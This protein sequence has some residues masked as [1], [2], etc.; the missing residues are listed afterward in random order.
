MLEAQI[1]AKWF[2]AWA[3]AD[4]DDEGSLT[5]LKL[6]K[7]LYYAQGHHLAL[8]G[9]PLF[10]DEI[11]AWKHGPVVPSVYRAY[12]TGRAEQLHLRDDDPFEFSDVDGETTGLLIDIW[13]RYGSLAA[14]R[15]RE[16]THSEPPWNDAYEPDTAEIVISVKALERFFKSLYSDAR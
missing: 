2:L 11:Q 7:L 16:M 15:L 14:W 8:K 5:S 4:D 3:D 12:R 13:E 10:D 9:I 1:I 6:Q